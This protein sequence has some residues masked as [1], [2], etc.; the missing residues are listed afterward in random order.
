MAVSGT[1]GVIGSP[2]NMGDTVD[3]FSPKAKVFSTP[4]FG[5]SEAERLAGKNFEENVLAGTGTDISKPDVNKPE[6]MSRLDKAKMGLAGAKTLLD[7]ANAYNAYSAT[8]GQAQLNIMMARNQ[9]SDAI[10]R[11]HQAQLERQS[12]GYNMGQQALLSAAARGQDVSSAGVEK[13]Q[14]SYEAM[15]I[16]NGMQEQINSMKDTSVIPLTCDTLGGY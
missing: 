5:M 14:G 6:G 11:G 16:M 4:A 10:Y 7:I 2:Q 8:V 1:Q 9:A 13:I 12:E 15:G 3:A